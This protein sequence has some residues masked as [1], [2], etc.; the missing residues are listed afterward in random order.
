[1]SKIKIIK[2]IENIC[3]IKTKKFK[4]QFCIRQDM[5]SASST[6]LSKTDSCSTATKSSNSWIPHLFSVFALS[7]GHNS[8]LQCEQNIFV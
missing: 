7:S 3:R 2:L 8:P 4:W 6:K 1:M 5:S